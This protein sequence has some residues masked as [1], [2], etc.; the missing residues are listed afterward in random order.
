MI[1]RYYFVVL[2]VVLGGLR[3]SAQMP[4]NQE[5]SVILQGFWWDYW[6]NNYPFR[7]SDY[8]TDL[9]PRLKAIGINAIWIPPT[10]KNANQ[11]V[12][13][14]PFDHYD[15]GEKYQRGDFRTRMGSKDELLRLVAVMNAN[16]I[17]VVQDIVPNHMIGAGSDNTSG[18]ID[19]SAPNAPCTDQWKNF[20]YVCWETPGTDQSAT[21]YLGRKG[22]WPKN[23]WNF[24]PVPSCNMCDLCD[25]NSD[26]ICWQ[27]FGPDIA[28][29][30][31]AHGYS[32]NATYNPDQSTYSPYGNGGIGTDNGYMRKHFREWLTWYKKQMGFSGVRID[33]V[34]HFPSTVAEDFLYNLQNFSLWANGGNEMIAVGEW[35]GNASEL[36]NWTNAVQRRAGTFDFSLRAFH[37]NGGLRA[38]VYSSGSYDM[39]NLPS[40]QQN[41]R[42]IDTSGVRI[43]RTVPFINNHDTYRPTV[44][45]LGNI[46]GWN[47]SDELSEHI[48]PREPRLGAAYA[49][50]C[51][52]DGNPQIFFEDL[53]NI[54]NTS[55]RFTHLPSDTIDLPINSDIANIILAHNALDFKGGE[56]KVPSNIGSFWNIVT[57]SNNNDDILVIERSGKAIIGITDSWNVEQDVW[58]DTDFAVGTVLRDYSGG[59][60]TT[61]TVQCPTGGCGSGGPNRVNI[62]VRPVGYPSFAY[63][64]NYSDHGVHYHGYAIWAPDG[65]QLQNF[66]N[67]PITTTQEWEMADDLGDSHCQSLGQGGALPENSFSYRIVGKIFPAA[68]STVNYELYFNPLDTT[69]SNCIEFYNHGGDKIHCDC[70]LGNFTGSF[71]TPGTDGWLVMKIRHDPGDGC[72]ALSYCGSWSNNNVPTQ[73]AFVKISYNAPTTVSTASYPSIPSNPVVFWTGAAEDNDYDNPKNWENCHTPDQM[74]MGKN[75]LFVN[76]IATGKNNGSSW[77]DAFTSLQSALLSASSCQNIDEIW[78]AEGTYLPTSGND[79]N[80]SFDIPPGISIYGGFP[81]NGNPN[82]SQR[83]PAT[84]ITT[85]SGDIGVLN[86]DSDNSYHVVTMQSANNLSKL[87]GFTIK[88]GNANGSNDQAKGGGLFLQGNLMIKNVKVQD[89]KATHA[90]E[91]IYN[92][93]ANSILKIENSQI[94]GVNTG[95][96]S[97]VNEGTAQIEITSDSQILD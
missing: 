28:Y 24:H 61:T 31:C 83:D 65:I 3:I 52:M 36:D 6:N 16:G 19:P 78:V 54:A 79:R 82:F 27:G 37:P 84:N 66:S 95:V 2:L 67:P 73:K 64:T 71:T 77:A 90:G 51:A 26:P 75:I 1:N 5:K 41:I 7:W 14:A 21:D 81:D 9:A 43:H 68:S 58:V 33:A 42:Y 32:S 50:A 60:T 93:G 35:V 53:F 20:R 85:L 63:Q 44:D 34:K 57:S 39:G 94:Y 55:K 30:D 38:M 87:D 15:L 29:N 59:Y 18:G 17:K 48:D 22:R 25:P 80:I 69:V 13:Y 70:G 96:A 49:A 86:D 97:V 10:I 89:C 4:A 46:T 92:S 47:T 62:K 23:Y 11:G 72:D 76:K 56:Y 88:L 91:A 74:V 45:S 8:L 40:A 12:G